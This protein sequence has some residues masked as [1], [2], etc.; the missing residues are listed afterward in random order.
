MYYFDFWAQLPLLLIIALLLGF[1]IAAFLQ[2]QADRRHKALHR[3][4]ITRFIEATHKIEA[5]TTELIQAIP[6][7]DLLETLQQATLDEL[8]QIQ[9]AISKAKAETARLEQTY[10]GQIQNI[11]KNIGLIGDASKGAKQHDAPNGAGDGK[12]MIGDLLGRL[13]AAGKTDLDFNKLLKLLRDRHGINNP[14]EFAAL[15]EAKQQEIEAALKNN[16]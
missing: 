9:T 4:R 3:Q 5:T 12:K 10:L 2:S 15:P 14:A 6:Q 8:Q 13:K 11:G 7:P 1:Q 16:H